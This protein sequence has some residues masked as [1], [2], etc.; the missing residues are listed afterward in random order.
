M[1]Q[2]VSVRQFMQ[3][4]NKSPYHFYNFVKDFDFSEALTFM[5]MNKFSFAQRY[6]QIDGRNKEQ[7]ENSIRSI[8]LTGSIS[9][10]Y[11]ERETIDAMHDVIK[12]MDFIK[13]ATKVTSRHRDVSIEIPL[14]FHD[15]KSCFAIKVVRDVRFFEKQII[16]HKLYVES[17]FFQKILPFYQCYFLAI[18]LDKPHGFGFF[19]IDQDLLNLG[20][21][22]IEHNFEVLNQCEQSNTYPSYF[23]GGAKTINKPNYL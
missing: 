17:A 9:Y 22:E 16:E 7:R 4:V 5:V 13:D 21:S 8:K 23:D 20:L 3:L 15:E 18:E 1:T 14:V 19:K 2:N 11:N 6:S 10:S 12:S